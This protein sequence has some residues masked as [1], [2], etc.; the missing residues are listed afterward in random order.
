MGDAQGR[1]E[2]VS[3]LDRH[4]VR[5]RKSLGQH[6]V[7]D[8]NVVDK[9]IRM[10]GVGR[11]DLV[12]EI[13]AGTGTL[14]RALAARGARVRAYEIDA[15][16]APVLGEVLEGYAD[17]EVVIGDAA[18]ADLPATL[19]GGPWAL[20]ANLPY[21]VGTPLLL[22]LMRHAPQVTR[23]AV[24]VQREVA[25]RLTA[26][27]GSKLY[28]LPT[29]VTALHAR[30]TAPLARLPAAVFYPPPRVESA[31]VAFERRP[32]VPAFAED[33][34]RIAAAAFGQR[35]K[36]LRQAL[37]TRFADPG[38]LLDAAGIDPTRRAET[39]TIGEFLKLASAE[40]AD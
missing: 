22:D 8:P 26:A 16:L 23:Y 13:G 40:A 35:R 38:A 39:L 6:F 33:A 7:I 10:A 24:M 3:L 25:E 32:D 36:M 28:G 15:R 18:A 20:V 4:G 34:V 31:L 12:V 30:V 17:V 1:R 21:N 5:P 29:V 27:P 14:T 9:L 2:L 11:G 19:P 37:K